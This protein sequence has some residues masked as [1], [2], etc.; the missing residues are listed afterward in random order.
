[1]IACHITCRRTLSA[2]NSTFLRRPRRVC[3]EGASSPLGA[4][5]IVQLRPGTSSPRRPISR[6]P[7]RLTRRAGRGGAVGRVPWLLRLGWR[8]TTR[9]RHRPPSLRE[10]HVGLCACLCFLFF[11]LSSCSC[12]FSVS[13][14]LCVLTSL[15]VLCC[16]LH[17]ACGVW[18]VVCGVFVVCGVLMVCGVWCVA[19]GGW[20]VVPG[21]WCVVRGAWCAVRGAWC[22]VPHLGS[23]RSVA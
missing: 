5:R 1:M 12:S 13:E 19:R 16:V 4:R 23:G 21:A 8:G 20:R 14:Y 17:L 2:R 7:L 18:C 9:R 10:G 3:A 22:V 15:P 11:S 6:A